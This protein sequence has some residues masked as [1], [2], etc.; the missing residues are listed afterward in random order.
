MKTSFK[1]YLGLAT[2]L[3]VLA[4]G[5]A[6]SAIDDDTTTVLVKYNEA[7][8]VY[9]EDIALAKTVFDAST[10]TGLNMYQGAWDKAY[11]EHKLDSL[12]NWFYEKHGEKEYNKL[13][14]KVDDNFD[15][16]INK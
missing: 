3:F 9:H 4:F 8:S 2:L 13:M 7:I 12:L 14:L 15:R 10:M 1:N 11:E 16:K 6:C 5:A